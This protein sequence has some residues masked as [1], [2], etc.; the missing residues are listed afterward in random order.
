V[1]PLNRPN[2]PNFIALS[3]VLLF[4]LNYAEPLYF[5]Y[6]NNKLSLAL[7]PVWE[8]QQKAFFDP[9]CEDRQV[10]HDFL[11]V[12]VS[13]NS[14]YSSLNVGRLLWLN[15]YCDEALAVWEV[16]ARSCPFASLE[17]VRVG[18]YDSLPTS[19]SL[20]LADFMHNY[21]QGL[22]Q[23]GDDQLAYDWF[24]RAFD[25]VPERR[26]AER[27]VRLEIQAGRTHTALLLWN[28]MFS[29]LPETHQDHWWAKG[30]YHGLKQEWDVAALAYV[31]GT[32]LTED[33]FP[34]WIEAG[35]AWEYSGNFTQAVFAYETAQQLSLNDP[36][37]YLGLGHVHRQQ[38]NYD[39]ALKW[40]FLARDVQP[41]GSDPYYYLALTYYMYGDDLLAKE[42]FER[43][44]EINPNYFDS[45]YFLAQIYHA[46]GDLSLAERWMLA[47]V[48][49]NPN[50]PYSWWLLLGDWQL[51]MTNCPGARFSYLS[52]VDVANA[53]QDLIAE[54]LRALNQIC[55]I[56]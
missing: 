12:S 16:A 5:A 23:Q 46:N 14:V 6:Q 26:S 42:N 31:Q 2:I 48:N 53:N 17:L 43:S 18:T 15:G 37:S 11:T 38:E 40:Y 56:D 29:L 19:V 20:Q 13:D 36:R 10:L 55:G 54:K 22:L 34:F 32:R 8:I 39:L 33:P 35:R 24:R 1:Y 3:F 50:P 30:R 25:L 52:A 44:L 45:K 47:A 21:A 4:V 49:S 7:W 27:I 28:D 41:Y 9:P 51:E